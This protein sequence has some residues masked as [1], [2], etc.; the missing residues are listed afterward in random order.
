MK[1]TIKSNVDFSKL[2]R[3]IE[4]ITDKALNDSAKGSALESKKTIDSKILEPLSETTIRVREE[5]NFY[6]GDGS[7]RRGEFFIPKY[8]K[9]GLKSITKDTPLKYT[10]G[11]YDSL[12]ANK[13]AV[14]GKEYGLKHDKG[15]KVSGSHASWGVPPRPFLSREVP[16]GVEE[17]FVKNVQKKLRK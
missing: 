10:G 1:M 3:N 14:I 12:K 8:K 13:G 11:L 5:G 7:G 17:K 9:Q 2:A 4:S 16:E 15:Y 6:E